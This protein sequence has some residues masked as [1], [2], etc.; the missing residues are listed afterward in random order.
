MEM[1]TLHYLIYVSIL[2]L[3]ENCQN[4]VRILTK[5]ADGK[6]LVCGT[7]AFKPLCRYY[8]IINGNYTMAEEKSGQAVCPYDPQHNS[9]AIYVGE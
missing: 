6:L 8:N 5:T 2:L 3:Q 9:T 4:Y 1:S 7:N